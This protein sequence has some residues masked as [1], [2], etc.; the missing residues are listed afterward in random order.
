MDMAAHHLTIYV[1][2]L[3]V[4]LASSPTLHWHHSSFDLSPLPSSSS[5]PF[6]P[7]SY[8]ETPSVSPSPSCTSLPW[9]YTVPL[10]YLPVFSHRKPRNKTRGI[11]GCSATHSRSTCTEA[12]SVVDEQRVTVLAQPTPV[13]AEAWKSRWV[14]SK[15]KSD[16]GMLVLSAG[17]FY[18]DAEAD[19]GERKPQMWVLCKMVDSHAVFID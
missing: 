14:E 12:S 5:S 6:Y 17:K 11:D 13:C 10:I 4:R 15:H 1:C 18:G 8:H 7:H 3:T 2:L 9:S 19:K 16:Y